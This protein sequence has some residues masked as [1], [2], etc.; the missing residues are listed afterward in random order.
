MVD[1]ATE[2]AEVSKFRFGMSVLTDDGEEGSLA[3]VGVDPA[4]RAISHAGVKFGFGPFGK[5]YCVP[6]DQVRHANEHEIRLIPTREEVER[7]F[8]TK[9]TVPPLSTGTQVMAGGKRIGHVAQLTV[10]RETRVLRHLVVDRGLQEV[11][12]SAQR[13]TAIEGK[14]II[15][16]LTPEDVRA[17]IPYVPDEALRDESH[18]AIDSNTRLRVDVRGVAIR[19]IDGVVWLQ[20]HVSS[21]L[22]V[23]Q[24]QDQLV[25]IRGIGEVQNE[26]IADTDLAAKVSYALAH[27]PST[28]QG[29]IGVYP[30]LGE[31]HLRGR[32]RTGAM[33]QAAGEIARRVPGV[34]QVYNELVVDPNASVLPVLAG[35]TGQEDR[36]PGGR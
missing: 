6:L 5:E 20:G 9:P 10:N 12:V 3:Y 18:R 32:V 34:A 11:V 31:V 21:D 33:R 15:T 26:L 13:V 29:Y 14:Q 4:Q 30:M 36:V 23:R 27:D 1:A 19:V 28:R 8:A 24:F 35:V 17:L 16:D 7:Q 22:N 2:F 25:G